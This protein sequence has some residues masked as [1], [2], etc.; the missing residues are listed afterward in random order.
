MQMVRTNKSHP[1]IPF[2]YFLDQELLEVFRLHR[3]IDVFVVG[4]VVLDHKRLLTL[5]KNYI[6]T[7]IV[8][9]AGVVGCRE[10]R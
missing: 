1:S 3:Q 10:Y 6:R 8:H 5:L 2:R 9:V 4:C 7:K